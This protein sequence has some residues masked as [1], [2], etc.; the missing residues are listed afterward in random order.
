MHTPI[1]WEKTVD[2]KCLIRTYT[3]A[4]FVQALAFVNRVGEIAETLQH[5]PDITI[6]YNKVVLTLTTHDSGGLTDKDFEMALKINEI[7]L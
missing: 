3:F 2:E 6:T 1:N 7:V 5:H 4:D